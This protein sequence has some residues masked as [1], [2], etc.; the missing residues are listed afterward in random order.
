[1]NNDQLVEIA[2]LHK[3]IGSYIGGL[4]P[5]S[6]VFEIV[7]ENNKVRLNLI[8]V[9]PIHRQSFLFHTTIGHDQVDALTKMLEYVKSYK[10]KESSFTIQWSVRGQNDLQ[11]SYF[12]AKNIF[13]AM[14]KLAF[15]RDLNSLIVYSIVLNPIS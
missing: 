14:N 11:T 7:N 10:E 6:L 1:M 13:E 15:G 8:T 3:S 4:E 5:D 12:R 9:N 2:N